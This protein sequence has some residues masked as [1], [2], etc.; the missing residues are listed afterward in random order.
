MIFVDESHRAGVPLPLL[1]LDS[2]GPTLMALGTPEQKERIL[3]GIFRG[4]VH[5]SIGYTE[6]SAGTDLAALRTQAGR[7]GHERDARSQTIFTSGGVTNE[8]QRDI[9]A[10]VGLGMSRAPR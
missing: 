2:V 5:F 3:S 9:I 4:E 8:V 7:H 10:M 1:T 6:P